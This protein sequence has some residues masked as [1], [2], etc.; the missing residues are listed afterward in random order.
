MKKVAVAMVVLVLSVTSGPPCFGTE[1]FFR[2]FPELDRSLKSPNDPAEQKLFDKHIAEYTGPH[3]AQNC[4]G[5]VHPGS[6][7]PLGVA[8]TS[9]HVGCGYGKRAKKYRFK[10]LVRQEN[11]CFVVTKNHPFAKVRKIDSN[12]VELVSMQEVR[13]DIQLFNYGRR[14]LD[15]LYRPLRSGTVTNILGKSPQCLKRSNRETWEIYVKQKDGR[16]KKWKTENF[17]Y[18]AQH[19]LLL[20][21]GIDPTQ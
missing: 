15:Y 8:N 5:G 14:G 2:R 7:V 12:T 3:W 11:P 17:F 10:V 16:W 9:V 4:L 19:P 18:D 21:L 20:R 1:E 6:Y 13:C